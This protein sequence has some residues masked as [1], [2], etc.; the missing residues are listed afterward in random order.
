MKRFLFVFFVF[1][2]STGFGKSKGVLWKT[3]E[4]GSKLAVEQEK[5]MMVFIQADWCHLCK[6]MEDKVF[7]EEE[8]ASLIDKYYVPVKL[9]IEAKDK[10]QKDGKEFTNMELIAELTKGK[11]GGIPAT[12]FVPADAKKEINLQTGLK[13]PDEMKKLLRKNK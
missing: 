1:I 3:W 6:R 12:L 4:E 8:V 9:N 13:D 11:C 2:L 7:T 10:V 5:P